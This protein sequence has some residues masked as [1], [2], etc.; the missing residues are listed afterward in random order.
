MEIWPSISCSREIQSSIS[1]SVSSNIPARHCHLRKFNQIESF[2]INYFIAVCDKIP[3]LELLKQ[4]R[5]GFTDQVEQSQQEEDQNS[6]KMDVESDEV[7]VENVENDEVKKEVEEEEENGNKNGSNQMPG[8]LSQITD[9]E[10]E[11][12]FEVIYGVLENNEEISDLRVKIT[13]TSPEIR[14][15]EV[16]NF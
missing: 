16:G 9:L 2:I 14:K 13:L 10:A 3:T 6:D 7:K 1:H 5:Q 4:V 8:K 11:A 12:G 15:A